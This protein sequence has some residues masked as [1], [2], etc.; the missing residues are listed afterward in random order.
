METGKVQYIVDEKGE[1]AWT[2]SRELSGLQKAG[3]ASLLEVSV[4][5]E[6]L[7][8]PRLHHHDKAGTVREPPI[9]VGSILVQLPSPSEP[10][11]VD[12]EDG[13]PPRGKDTVQE[14]DHGLTQGRSGEAIG[15]LGEDGIGRDVA[16]AAGEEIPVQVRRGQMEGVALVGQGKPRRRVHEHLERG[17]PHLT[18]SP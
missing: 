18:G 13:D 6:R 3:I 11:R 2:E 8:D 9:F 12:G 16:H 10:V 7:A 17:H 5:R 4:T 15:D 14:P 1:R